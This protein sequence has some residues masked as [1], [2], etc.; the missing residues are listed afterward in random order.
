MRSKTVLE[1]VRS[2]TGTRLRLAVLVAAILSVTFYMA[3]IA[4]RGP[5]VTTG[6]LQMGR[7]LGSPWMRTV[8]VGGDPVAIAVN[9]AGT[10]AYLAD[11][12]TDAVTVVDIR[13]NRVMATIPVTSNPTDLAISPNGKYVIVTGT[14]VRPTEPS[15]VVIDAAS[16]NVMARVKVEGFSNGVAFGPDGRFAYITTG[17]LG[18]AVLDTKTFRIIK[19]FP[20]FGGY[21]MITVNKSGTY[22]VADS[23]FGSGPNIL[24]VIDI[25]TGRVHAWLDHANYSPTGLGIDPDG[26]EIYETFSGGA[27]VTDMGV[28]VVSCKTDKLVR[29]IPIKDG[30]DGIAFSPN[31][32]WAFVSDADG[33][34]LSVINVRTNAVVGTI[35]ITLPLPGPTPGLLAVDPRGDYIYTANSFFFSS[36][37]GTFMTVAMPRWLMG[38]GLVVGRK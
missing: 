10:R 15:V 19:T 27:T 29:T 8:R 5:T 2:P 36:T 22:L 9:R 23:G 7:S 6:G 13:A 16:D 11:A 31:G 12:G 14:V 3:V 30:A 33:K 17:D 32:R 24:S 26:S 1:N 28:W 38:Q 21:S 37:E 4:S 20:A 34:G 18:V 35:P 25:H